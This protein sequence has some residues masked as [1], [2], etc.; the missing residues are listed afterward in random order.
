MHV[1]THLA[2]LILSCVQFLPHLQFLSCFSI[3]VHCLCTCPEYTWESHPGIHCLEE[4]NG[5]RGKRMSGEE[6][7]GGRGNRRR[8]RK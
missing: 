6:E 8:E 2:S 7:G 4:S 5:G 1:S 3:S